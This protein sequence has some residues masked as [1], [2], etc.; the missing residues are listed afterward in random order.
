VYRREQNGRVTARCNW[1]SVRATWRVGIN[2]AV[3]NGTSTLHP[4]TEYIPLYY[5][6]TI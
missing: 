5:C 1:F 2:P 3:S 4:L 6:S